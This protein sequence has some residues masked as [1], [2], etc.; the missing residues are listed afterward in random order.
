MTIDAALLAQESVGD[1][2]S[3][4]ADFKFTCFR[5]QWHVPEVHLGGHV[6][7]TFLIGP[8]S[9]SAWRNSL[10]GTVSG[11]SLEEACGTLTDTGPIE[12]VTWPLLGMGV[13]DIQ[14]QYVEGV[15]VSLSFN[16]S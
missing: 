3:F 16:R 11:E 15:C 8:L 12:L 1:G 6:S 5:I 10:W 13:A 9:S 7:P 14:F 4:D 2:F